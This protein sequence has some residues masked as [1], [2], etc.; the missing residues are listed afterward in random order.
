MA[1]PNRLYFDTNIFI[2]L[3]EGNDELS[4]ALTEL[5]LLEPKGEK[6]F[7]TTSELTLAEM[8]VAPC[9]D[10]N[11]ELIDRYNGWIATNDYLEVGPVDRSVL[12]AAA[13]LRGGHASLK[14]PDAIHVATALRFGCTH[15]MTADAGLG[16]TYEL[17]HTHRGLVFGPASIEIVRPELALVRTVIE[18]RQ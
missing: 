12:W 13:V 4:D 16:G 6:P 17:Y 15:F 8:L 9:R 10:D 11:D 5:L 3:F 18:G 14:L 2:R 1:L 7:V